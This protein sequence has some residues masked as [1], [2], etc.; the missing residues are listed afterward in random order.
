MEIKVSINGKK[1]NFDNYTDYIKML[2]QLCLEI[3]KRKQSI[4]IQVDKREIEI[5]SSNFKTTP[6]TNIQPT[7]KPD[8]ERPIYQER[9]L[10]PSPDIRIVGPTIKKEE[11]PIVNQKTVLV[12]PPKK[13]ETQSDIAINNGKL[14]KPSITGRYSATY[15][16]TPANPEYDMTE[17]EKNIL[18]LN[19]ITRE[20]SKE[21]NLENTIKP[22]SQKVDIVEAK[23]EEM[24]PS[25]RRNK[26]DRNKLKNIRQQRLNIISLD[27]DELLSV[28]ESKDLNKIPLILVPVSLIEKNE[29]TFYDN[30]EILKKYTDNTKI[31]ALVS[32]KTTTMEKVAKEVSKI[33][34]LCNGN[35]NY[36]L[37]CYEVNNEIKNL[38]PEKL[39]ESFNATQQTCDI[40]TN[41]GYKVLISAD[42]DVRNKFVDNNLYT[43]YPLLVRISPKELNAVSENTDI[44][45]MD[46]MTPN[47]EILLTKQTAQYLVNAS[48]TKEASSFKRVA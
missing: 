36:P 31:G 29:N 7:N 44:I 23:K 32:G 13:I 22:E 40:L 38:E 1:C 5:N 19:E 24:R 34:R 41:E 17:A 6:N 35:I 48:Q 45:L 10:T 42:L 25:S 12:E 11:P 20:Y 15:K 43:K 28:E 47:D 39:T 37:I 21:T 8:I 18:P 26:V 27:S 33:I 3:E 16:T 4:P 2:E 46:P 30:I 14:V 9:K